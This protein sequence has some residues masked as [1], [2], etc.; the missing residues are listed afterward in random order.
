[1]RYFVKIGEHYINYVSVRDIPS[2][3]ANTTN[4]KKIKNWKK[5]K[6]IVYNEKEIDII[7]NLHT[8]AEIIE[9]N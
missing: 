1:M 7:K 5:M 2:R 8:D 9:I 6:H 3:L 4:S